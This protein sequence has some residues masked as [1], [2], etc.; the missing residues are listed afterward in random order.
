MNKS[1]LKK[2][3]T[4]ALLLASILMLTASSELAVGAKKMPKYYGKGKPAKPAPA[5][6][7]KKKK[8]KP[9]KEKYRGKIERQLVKGYSEQ[10]KSRDWFI[11]SVCISMVAK[12]RAPAS[13]ECLLTHLKKERKDIVKL[14]TWEAI[15]TRTADLTPEQHKRWVKE[16]LTML[17]KNKVPGQFRVGILKAAAS[18]GPKAFENK[19]Y[20]SALATLKTL[21]HND[22]HS[23]HTLKALRAMTKMW[24]DEKFT[25]M[26]LG[27]MTAN[28]F[29]PYAVEY[30]AGGLIPESEIPSIGRVNK[31]V[32]RAEWLKQKSKMLKWVRTAKLGKFKPSDELY[33][34]ESKLFPKAEK[35]YSIRNPKW[36]S[37]LEMDKIAI[38]HFDLVFCLDTTSSMGAGMQWMARDI[39]KMMD[40]L[41]MICR[42]PRMGVTLY[43]DKGDAYETKI[44]PLSGR[45]NKL[46]KK[47][48]KEKPG[49][50]GDHP[51]GVYRAFIDTLKRHRWSKNQS[52]KKVIVVVGDAPPHKENMKKIQALISKAVTKGYVFHSIKV[53]NN[54]NPDFD[55]IAKVGK[56]GTTFINF[57]NKYS[58]LKKKT[59]PKVSNKQIADPPT[60]I[61]AYKDI[62]GKII[63]NALGKNSNKVAPLVNYLLIYCDALYT[64]KDKKKSRR[65]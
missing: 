13:T 46:L 63:G 54:R 49:G 55:T 12:L 20:R 23:H 2:I 41:K 6:K 56:G 25:K 62:M 48:R 35:I 1:L 61:S 38:K 40:I 8:Y 18:Y 32:R 26:L 21:R 52:A 39:C 4:P 11:R 15:H 16:G 59:A 45:I 3:A 37:D 58:H 27:K 43:R 34:G 10:L 50:G 51:E 17:S 24:R 47:F 14:L 57:R 36:R 28:G 31:K 33:K 64:E 9:F 30:V 5:P 65:R 44:L 19:V 53:N 29:S 42:E 22:P 7:P 60:G